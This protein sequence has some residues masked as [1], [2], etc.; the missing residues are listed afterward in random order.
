MTEKIPYILL[1]GWF[2]GI[3]LLAAGAY[4]PPPNPDHAK[5]MFDAGSVLTV[6]T[7]CA[8]VVAI[9]VEWWDKEMP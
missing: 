5:A 3:A 2:S 8:T 1:I 6:V 7:A 9:L 4:F